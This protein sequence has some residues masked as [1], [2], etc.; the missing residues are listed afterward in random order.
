MSVTYRAKPGAGIT[1]G[2]TGSKQE[3]AKIRE[4]IVTALNNP[5]YRSRT[6][7]GIS[8]ETKLKPD[9]ILSAIK[10]DKTLA[11]EVKIIPIRSRDGRILL[12]TKNRFSREASLKERFVDFFASKRQEVSNA[13]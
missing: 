11:V 5:S 10:N 12:T 9:V 6:L 3:T 8:R 1:A 4:K 2:L 7:R 13:K